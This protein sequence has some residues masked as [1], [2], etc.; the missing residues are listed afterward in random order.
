MLVTKL[1]LN[2]YSEITVSTSLQAQVLTSSRS[3]I[4]RHVDFT[5]GGEGAM[6]FK[7]FRLEV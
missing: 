4:K 1:K 2:T 6:S 7:L 5:P 3:I